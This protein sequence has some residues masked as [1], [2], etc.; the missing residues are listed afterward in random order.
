MANEVI[1]QLQAIRTKFDL[2]NK[3]LCQL[4]DP[5]PLKPLNFFD[6]DAITCDNTLS[7]IPVTN[8]IQTVPHPDFVWAG[9]TI[10]ER[11]R[12]NNLNQ[13]FNIGLEYILN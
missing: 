1:T 3:T 13:V 10:Y 4:L 2:L 7:S 12:A 11:P 9:A 5:Q 8:V 6:V